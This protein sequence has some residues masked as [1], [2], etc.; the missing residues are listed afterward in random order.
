MRGGGEPTT[1]DPFDAEHVE[2]VVSLNLMG[3]AHCIAAVLP[4]MLERRSGHLVAMSSLAGLR[5]LPGAAAYSAAKGA[6]NNLMES[7]RLDLRGRGV[8]VTTLQPGFVRTRPR[9]PGAKPRRKPLRL[10]LEE[11]T[12]LMHRAI[13]ARRPRYAFPR[14]LVFAL[15]VTRVLPRAWVDP[16]LVRLGRG[17][18]G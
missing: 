6:V 14:A 2:H 13:Q 9:K 3:T 5:G 4:G 8:D 18:T 16:L 17:A 10:E 11:A 12:E 7:L 1:V 15:W